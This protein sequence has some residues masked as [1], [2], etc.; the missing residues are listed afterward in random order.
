LL[1]A[2]R[3]RAESVRWMIHEGGAGGDEHG[4]DGAGEDECGRDRG[5]KPAESVCDQA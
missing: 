5:I 3:I 4:K 2:Y 1:P